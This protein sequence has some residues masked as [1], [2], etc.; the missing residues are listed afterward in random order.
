M[1]PST[2]TL[3]AA[4]IA[5]SIELSFV[6]VF[7]TFL[8]QVLSRRA[9]V[10][11]SK[12]ITISEMSMRSWVMQPGTLLTHF[13]TV[14]H[15]AMTLLGLMALTGALVAML[16]TTASESLVAPKLKMGPM[17]PRV[18]YGKVAT[19]FANEKY[20]EQSCKTPVSAQTDPTCKSSGGSFYHL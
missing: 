8:G 18:L 19:S 14:R 6:T 16:Y 12:G 10:Q 13:Q 17:E 7:V 5:K 4:A 1:S 3:V 2:A 20:I 15:T 9:F 11:R